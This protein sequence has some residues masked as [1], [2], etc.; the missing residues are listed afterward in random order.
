MNISD[1]IRAEIEAAGGTVTDLSDE[2]RQLW[3]ASAIP[4][5][6]ENAPKVDTEKLRAILKAAGNTTF[7]EAIQ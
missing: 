4:F 7:L 6:K 1:K 3:I 5:Y 2:E